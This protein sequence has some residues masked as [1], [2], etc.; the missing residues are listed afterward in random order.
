[1][2]IVKFPGVN[3]E[4]Q[5]SKIAISIFGVNIYK[6]AICIVLGIVVALILCK[7]SKEN[8]G[9]E[10]DFVVENFVI[11]IVFGI[12]GAR[13][14]FVIFNFKYYYKNVLEIFKIRDGG[15]AIYG[16]LIFGII[17]VM[18][19]C[20][21]KKKDI[22]NLLDYIV[23]YIAIAQC[24]GRF[25]NFFN[26]EAYGYET[27]SIFRMG[28]NT[29]DGYKEVHPAFLYEAISTFLIF[30]ILKNIQKKRKFKGE[31]FLL[32]LL[33]YSGIRTFIEG[34]RQDSLM[35][36]NCRISQIL[37]III[38]LVI[39]MILI[40]RKLSNEKQLKYR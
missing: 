37:S 16:G 34:L 22:L 9:V 2:N 38:F 23:P 36:F 20:K 21:I 1:M 5:F 27:N 19:N 31:I 32:Y 24:I 35:L 33:F 17:S 15:L 30:I 3:L 25:G 26:V 14:Y 4:F 7:L 28:I 11:G 6:Y 13:L 10:F 8:Y 40:C 12:I 39:G 18:I 29:L